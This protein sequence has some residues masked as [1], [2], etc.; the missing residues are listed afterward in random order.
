M[1]VAGSKELFHDCYEY[2]V[3]YCCKPTSTNV[4]WDFPPRADFYYGLDSFSIHGGSGNCVYL[5]YE[6]CSCSSGWY[7]CKTLEHFKKIFDA[8]A[9]TCFD[10]ALLIHGVQLLSLAKAEAPP[11]AVQDEA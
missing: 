6:A 7:T 5:E 4:L 10:P 11:L 3:S 1:E 8:F 2:I 9:V